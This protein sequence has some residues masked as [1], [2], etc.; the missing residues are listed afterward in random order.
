MLATPKNGRK[1]HAAWLPTS[2]ESNSQLATTSVPRRRLKLAFF[3]NPRV[4]RQSAI[5]PLAA[6]SATLMKRNSGYSPSSRP[7]GG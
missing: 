1:N 3:I 2:S 6:I 5:T 7:F 4:W